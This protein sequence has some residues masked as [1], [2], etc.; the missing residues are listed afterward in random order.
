MSTYTRDNKDTVHLTRPVRCGVLKLV[1]RKGQKGALYSLAELSGFCRV[2]V[3][4]YLCIA[5]GGL[6]SLAPNSAV[7]GVVWH[8]A[9]LGTLGKPIAEA[10]YLFVNVTYCF[11]YGLQGRRKNPPWLEIGKSNFLGHPKSA[12]NE[13]IRPHLGIAPT[14]AGSNI[15]N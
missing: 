15:L 2:S 1:K 3:R 9:K 5:T 11:C 10:M 7:H 12:L 13:Q 8:T 6:V 4:C 14:P